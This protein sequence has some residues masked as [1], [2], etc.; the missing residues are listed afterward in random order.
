MIG[1]TKT[2]IT[3]TTI[4]EEFDI[5]VQSELDTENELAALLLMV[6][7]KITGVSTNSYVALVDSTRS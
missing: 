4:G 3:T 7:E 2:V 6:V 1:S 5:D